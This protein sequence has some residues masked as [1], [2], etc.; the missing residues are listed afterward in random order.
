MGGIRIMRNTHT[1]T[2]LLCREGSKCLAIKLSLLLAQSDG[3]KDSLEVGLV[4]AGQ[5]PASHV[6]EVATE[7]RVDDLMVTTTTTTTTRKE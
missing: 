2:H 1:H 6:G 5:E 3:A 4:D 7:G